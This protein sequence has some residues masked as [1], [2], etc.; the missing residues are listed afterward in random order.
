RKYT[1]FNG[2]YDYNKIPLYRGSDG[3]NYYS[4]I[5]L[6]HYALGAYQ[7]YL[8]TNNKNHYNKFIVIADWFVQNQ[9][10]YITCNGIW[11]NRYPMHTFALD[12]K[13]SSCLS[14]AKGISTLIRAYYLTSNIKY[15]QS[16]LLGAESFLVPKGDGG[17]AVFINN[18]IFFEEYTTKSNS[19]VLNGHIFAIFAIFDLL[20]VLKN[21]QEYI[22]EYQKYNDLF[23]Q[24]ILILER[25]LFR[26][27]TYHWSRY[28]IWDEHFNI[29]SLFY[30][31][32]HIK[33]LKILF[34]ITK[35][36]SFNQLALK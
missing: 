23:N 29:S 16:A 12:N 24:S 14:Q 20:R 25:N 33:Q 1:E 11:V 3:K 28:D 31:K 36:D 22:N 7:E 19:I 26:W 32:L 5:F 18:D 10:K 4:S 27:E 17:V 2:D 30:H 13:W 6:G 8:S 34:N 35:V 21:K 15:L 9:E